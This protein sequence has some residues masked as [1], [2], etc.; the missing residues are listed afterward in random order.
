MY[1]VLN[2]FVVL[3]QPVRSCI[4]ERMDTTGHDNL[5]LF[6]LPSKKSAH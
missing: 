6:C 5:N 2:E 4:A 1:V 3:A